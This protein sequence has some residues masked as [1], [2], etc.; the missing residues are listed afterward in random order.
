M[1]IEE[2]LLGRQ[3]QFADWRVARL[4][5]MRAR[6]VAVTVDPE[7]ACE[8]IEIDERFDAAQPALVAA[9]RQQGVDGLEM[10]EVLA[11]AHRL[12][13]QE[14]W[15]LLERYRAALVRRRNVES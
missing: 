1:T 11:E 6:I 7:V 4:T 2:A 13:W 8:A 3:Q 12:F 9:L 15:G 14:R 5:D 10:P